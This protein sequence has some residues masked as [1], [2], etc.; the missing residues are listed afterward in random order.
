MQLFLYHKVAD[1]APFTAFLP[2]HELPG[3]AQGYF[4]SASRVFFIRGPLPGVP[5]LFPKCLLK[6]VHGQTRAVAL[7]VS[8]TNPGDYCKLPLLL[9]LLL[10]GR[11]SLLSVHW[12]A[13]A[14]QGHV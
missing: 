13:L 5:V 10:H 12:W 7:V 9:L 4:M 11:L 3:F 1:N 6:H 8:Y 14:F 2:F